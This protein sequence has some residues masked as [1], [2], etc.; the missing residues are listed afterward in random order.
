MKEGNP[1]AILTPEK[2]R[3]LVSDFGCEPDSVVVEQ[4]AGERRLFGIFRAVSRED[5]EPMIIKVATEKR[6]QALL[7]NEAYVLRT[8]PRDYLSENHLLV[9][10]LRGD[11]TES[12]GLTAIM[13][14]EL[15]QGEKAT[16]AGFGWALEVFHRM[17]IPQEMEIETIGPRDYLEKG[18]S[19]LAFLKRMGWLKGLS[20]REFRRI[21]ELYSRDWELLGSYGMAFVHGD[22]KRNHLWWAGEGLA[23]IDFDKSVW[24][25]ELEDPAWLSVRCP[26]FK[27][28]VIAYLTQRFG[29]DQEKLAYFD[30]AF[31]LMQTD[32]LIEAYFTRTVQWRGNMDV[33][34]YL[35]KTYG[36]A[37]L[38]RV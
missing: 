23:L 20:E 15:P 19:R 6:T 29:N 33:R 8:I 7:E 3:G 28:E 10:E 13:I 31:R 17:E 4:N 21:E 11:L 1:R 16:F 2:I 26:G 12:G 27:K 25:S 14:N 38:L 18:L 32:R 24:G 30:E 34:S 9:P 36:R 22:F 35:Q 37:L 5:G